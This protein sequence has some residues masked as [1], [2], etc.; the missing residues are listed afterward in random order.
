V[1]AILQRPHPVLAKPAHP[2][3]QRAEPTPA[4]RYRSLAEQHS[5][6]PVAIAATVCK[7]L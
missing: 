1:P 7:R 3:Q 2:P 5:P 4:D 6:I